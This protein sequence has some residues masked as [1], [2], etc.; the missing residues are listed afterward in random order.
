MRCLVL[1][2]NNEEA[3]E[4]LEDLEEANQ[5]LLDDSFMEIASDILNNNS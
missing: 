5:S 4:L 3:K 1:L 2:G